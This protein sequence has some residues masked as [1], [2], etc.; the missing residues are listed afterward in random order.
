MENSTM[1]NRRFAFALLALAPLTAGA[2][3]TGNLT[4]ENIGEFAGQTLTA[5]Q[6]G[7]PRDVY[8]SLL[9]ERLPGDAQIERR[10]VATITTIIYQNDLLTSMQPD[11][12]YTVFRQDCLRS[13]AEDG[14]KQ[15]EE[16]ATDEDGYQDTTV[17][18]LR[19]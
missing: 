13:L 14:A 16:G 12:A 8:L 15:D 10:L 18:E 2:Y 11:D 5:K 17:G 4:C 7:V 3:Q 9:N 19:T 1:S 6:S